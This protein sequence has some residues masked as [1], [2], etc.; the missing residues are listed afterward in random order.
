MTNGKRRNQGRVSP[1][2]RER[3][4]VMVMM[5]MEMMMD[6]LFLTVTYQMMKESRMEMMMN[7][8]RMKR[9]RERILKI[10]EINSLQRLKLGKLQ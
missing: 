4:K 8:M 3:K 6:S 5:T 1:T 10:E 9:I 7:V 2:V